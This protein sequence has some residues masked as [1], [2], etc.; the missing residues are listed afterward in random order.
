ME[1]SSLELS[2][3]IY[4]VVFLRDPGG[5]ALAVVAA[6]RAAGA[7][8]TAAIHQEAAWPED[9]IGPLQLLT[10][11]HGKVARCAAVQA[12]FVPEQIQICSSSKRHKEDMRVNT[13][14]STSRS[15]SEVHPKSP[16]S[17][18]FTMDERLSQHVP[19]WFVQLFH[20]HL[21]PLRLKV[22]HDLFHRSQA[23]HCF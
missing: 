4:L 5:N 20:I 6:V 23:F 22:P 18:F 12:N 11:R 17:G 2:V 3:S 21:P 10:Q 14:P 9:G 15:F 13:L 1:T 16:T 8:S 7:V 19:G